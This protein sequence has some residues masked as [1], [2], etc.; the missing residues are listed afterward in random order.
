MLW[1][2]PGRT[3]VGRR[4]CCA[5]T[6]ATSAK[7][8]RERHLPAA[9]G[10][11]RLVHT[12]SGT[13]NAGP[14]TEGLSRGCSHSS[15]PLLLPL[16]S[17]CQDSPRPPSHA[18][19]ASPPRPGGH[20]ATVAPTRVPRRWE[21]GTQDSVPVPS[22]PPS[23]TAGHARSRGGV[24]RPAT[25]STPKSA[26]TSAD[27]GDRTARPLWPVDDATSSGYVELTGK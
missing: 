26:S 5:H 3:R 22:P 15:R 8:V 17:L 20:S 9:Q 11:V 4:I 1:L 14:A 21:P 13:G 27:W 2:P 6:C 24:N 25:P 10:A 19:S 23:L 7:R 18:H 16:A 12:S